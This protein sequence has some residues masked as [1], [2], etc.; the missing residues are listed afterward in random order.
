[1]RFFGALF[2]C[3]RELLIEHNSQAIGPPT[4]SLAVVSVLNWSP[5]N[6]S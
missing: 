2:E 4:N 6:L 1:M 5:V 3:R